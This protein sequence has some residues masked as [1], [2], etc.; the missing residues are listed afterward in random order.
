MFRKIGITLVAAAV[1]ALVAVIAYRSYVSYQSRAQ[2]QEIAQRVGEATTLLRQGLT[3]SPSAEGVKGIEATLAALRAARFSRQRVLAD[4]ADDY[5]AGARAIVL[6]RVDVA[7]ASRQAALAR[8]ALIAHIGTRRGRDDGWIRQ[9][10]A[11][12][13]RADDAQFELNVACD[14]LIELLSRL[15]EPEQKL[16]A[17]VGAGRL[18]EEEVRRAALD[19][20]KEEASRAAAELEKLG[21]LSGR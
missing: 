7:R 11:L 8:Q 18:L 15:P 12:K 19:G 4:A 14:T 13:K 16:A 3:A 21:R 2:Q 5:T 9:A 17:Q 6:R 20:A 1:I 10:A